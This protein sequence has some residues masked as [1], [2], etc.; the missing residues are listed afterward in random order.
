M[1]RQHRT[2]VPGRIAAAALCV[3]A[4]LPLGA[5]DAP[6]PTA[7]DSVSLR[8]RMEWGG[9]TARRW[10]GLAEVADGELA[11]PVALGIEADEP[12]SMWSDG[13]RWHL[14]PRS[15]RTYDGVDVSLTARRDSILVVTLSDVD[16]APPVRHEIPVRSLLSDAY[17][18]PLDD[19][20][21]RIAVRRAPGCRLRT[22]ISHPSLIFA[23]GDVLKI[24]AR[25][26]EL[27]FAP[28]TDL[29]LSAT[30]TP[31]RQKNVLW[32]GSLDVSAPLDDGNWPAVPVN[33][34]VPDDEG[35]YDLLLELKPRAADP[36]AA[37]RVP[38]RRKVQFVVLS[39]KAPTRKT[40]A[41]P[42]PS[43][44]LQEIDPASPGWS[45][46][47][48]H[49]TPLVG[50]AR[51][52]APLG[53]VRL[54][55]RTHHRTTYA[56]M[57]TTAEPDDPA[58][59]AFPLTIAKPGTPHIIELE[60]P[61]DV[62]QSIGISLLEPNAAGAVTPLGVD[63]GLH[64]D[65]LD[66]EPTSR[67]LTRRIVIWP[68][69]TAPLLVL[70]NQRR[71]GPA[72]FGKIRL[73]GDG[74][75]SVTYL[76]RKSEVVEGL[77][78]APMPQA[79]ADGR[80]LAAYFDRP[81]F[82]ENFGAA[83]TV[84]AEAVQPD[85]CLDDWVTFYDGARRLFD[86]LA[87]SGYN[88][89]MLTVAADGSAI[90]PSAYLSP[91]PRYDDGTFFAAGQ[92]PLRK[93]VVEL[94]LRMCDREGLRFV[95]AVQFAT[96]L[97]GLEVERR[98]GAVNFE[99]R[100]P[101]G[102]TWSETHGAMAGA[103]PRY[104]PLDPR[105]QREMT[106]VV[107]EL[108]Q[109]YGHHP[110][111]AGVG[112]QLSADGYTQLPGLD[113]GLD[114]ETIAQF[115]RETRLGLS[116]HFRTADLA[117]LIVDRHRETWLAW[118]KESLSRFYRELTRVAAPE[119]SARRLY[120]IA[121]H[122]WQ[123]DDLHPRLQAHLGSR[124][125]FETILD[126]AGLGLP[127][128]VK[129]PRMEFLRPYVE[130]P[131]H[132]P[133]AHAAATAL[134]DDEALDRLIGDATSPGS[135]IF[136][137]PQLRRLESLERQSPF[138]PAFVRLIAESTAGGTA[139]RR[140][141]VRQLATLD[142]STTFCGGWTLPLGEQDDV[143]RLAQVIRA[144]PAERFTTIEGGPS[145]IVARRFDRE[146]KTYFYAVNDS[147]WPTTVK[148]NVMG[149]GE[150]KWLSFRPDTAKSELKYDNN[151]CY[152][153]ATLE[154]FDVIGGTFAWTG[155]TI[156][157][158]CLNATL[159]DG[160]AERLNAQVRQLWAR[161][162]ALQRAAPVKE[163]TNADFETATAPDTPAGWASDDP[164]HVRYDTTEPHGGKQ[165]AALVTTE[166]NAWL[167]SAPF[168][169]PPSGRMSIST[170]LRSA[171]NDR[172]TI[173][174]AL[175]GRIDGRPYFRYASV[176]T[177]GDGPELNETWRQF[178]FPLHDLPAEG[179]SDLRVRF[180]LIGAGEVYIDDVRLTELEFT[181]TERLELSKIISL[182]E[183]RLQRNEYGACARLLEGYWPRF[184]SAYVPPVEGDAKDG[185]PVVAAR[186]AVQ[187]PAKTE[188]GD[189]RDRLKKWVP[190]FLR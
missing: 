17:H 115:I 134:N 172:P 143:R 147:P 31:A 118:R 99:P 124:M 60:Y 96:P 165:C 37:P 87:H 92:D 57:P 177:S 133:A 157:L 74:P 161:N 82:P 51:R 113:W 94:L 79:P 66:V 166:G 190:E 173:R 14:E 186:R 183:Y 63:A 41:E 50:A 72:V 130:T 153:Q 76:S 179:L 90:Y 10:N 15:P 28:G 35:V 103:G 23:P 48:K 93:D 135:L 84:D 162:A 131:L 73:R 49:M 64:V 126:E 39:P 128:L 144:L 109:R 108:T 164:Q 132:G 137:P 46:R 110:S 178:V 26:H 89:L 167:H 29:T 160:T 1:I 102:R 111:L 171:P 121:A 2:F 71:D 163:L 53:N 8:L 36:Q 69:T 30:L 168:T 105:V 11:L 13:V 33:L 106:R 61:S 7:G 136:H 146:N 18:A 182:A 139:A 59:Q 42:T 159:P 80:L 58:W 68:Q 117:S 101:D 100:G 116:P 5:Q 129:E 65:P 4:A 38:E 114:A 62:A 86:Y 43:H 112:V 52:A 34:G 138:Q 187:P 123:R 119:T 95:P 156:E 91:T 175:E 75:V 150:V 98:A 189:L 16:G 9:G 70:V 20:G 151:T 22:E 149:G 25:P 125:P 158:A 81:L 24:D 54:T 32:T 185:A 56:E 55:T 145:H 77:S 88:G 40:S 176:G 155:V 142:A 67:T 169:P 44:V 104:N 19:A 127:Q 107:E 170:W 141:I 188:S 184:L 180:E 154:P 45:E 120:L 181:P 21:N 78:A 152:L 140:R 85:R 47:L 3:C 122:A 27:G 97:P 12:G 174:I 148:F 6:A 83:A